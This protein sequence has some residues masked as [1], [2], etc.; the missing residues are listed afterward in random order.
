MPQGH[1]NFVWYDLVTTD[2]QAAGSFYHDVI[3]WEIR[4][5][6]MANA[7]YFLLSMGS[8]T[9]GGLMQAPSAMLTE[10]TPPRWMGHIGVPDVEESATRLAAAG[11]TVHRAPSDIAGIGRYAAVADPDGARLILF[12]PQGGSPPAPDPRMPGHVGWRELHAGKMETAFV[13]Y[14]GLFGWT[15]AGSV[16]M[17]A[18]GIYRM[19]GTDASGVPVGGMLTRTAEMPEA[20]WLYYFTVDSV[21]AAVGR[22]HKAGGQV[23]T[24]PRQVPGGGWIAHCSDPQ[25][26]RFAVTAERE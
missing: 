11:G 15:E 5:A 9:I 10:G 24:E 17:G 1:G 16:D 21:K 20:M 23:L 26:A 12:Q 7:A 22:V 18:M 4:D 25:G 2:V 13:F 6:G 14:A 19:F 8:E 3:G